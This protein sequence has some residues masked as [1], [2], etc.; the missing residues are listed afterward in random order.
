MKIKDLRGVSEHMKRLNQELNANRMTPEVRA[1]L[2]AARLGNG[3]GKTYEKTYGVH[4]HRVVAEQHI[5]RKLRKGE[6][7][8]HIDGN[9]RNN[10]A[11]NLMVFKSQKEHSAYHMK[12][13]RSFRGEVMPK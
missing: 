3:E 11:D 13:K 7:V 10:D 4:T 12:L 8:H 2:R 1:K 9:K 5:G 6:T